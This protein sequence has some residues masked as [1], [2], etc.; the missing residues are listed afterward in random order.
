MPEPQGRIDRH[1]IDAAKRRLFDAVAKIEG[2]NTSRATAMQAI[3]EARQA[4]FE[5][6][7]I[8]TGAPEIENWQK[9]TYRR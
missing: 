2:E 7:R 4:L 6:E 8:L 3:N 5:L 1:S 9:K